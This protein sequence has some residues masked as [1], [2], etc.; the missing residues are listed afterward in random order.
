MTSFSKCACDVNSRF[1]QASIISLK[2]LD[3][4]HL[5]L[6]CICG[7]YVDITMLAQMR[8]HSICLRLTCYIQKFYLIDRSDHV[9]INQYNENE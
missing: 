6:W 3:S 1:T 5:H 2:L 8:P 7:S 4:H 9:D